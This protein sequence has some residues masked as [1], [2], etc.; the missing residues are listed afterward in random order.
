MKF[1]AWWQ[2]GRSVA[3][4]DIFPVLPCSRVVSEEGAHQS[5]RTVASQGLP[6]GGWLGANVVGS[7]AQLAQGAC[8]HVR[9]VALLWWRWDGAVAATTVGC[10][11]L[12]LMMQVKHGSSSRVAAR[13][14]GHASP[15]CCRTVTMG[16]LLR[17]LALGTLPGADDC[18][19]VVFC[20]RVSSI[21]NSQL[22]NHNTVA[23]KETM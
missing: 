5:I 17:E 18:L 21:L 4:A 10:L 16:P 12:V 13:V 14:A 1:V 22:H 7:F 23:D 3:A 6:H 8:M 11:L 2:A 15:I 9:L 20:N 19:C